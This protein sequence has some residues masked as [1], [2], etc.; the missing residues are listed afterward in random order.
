[1]NWST[2][3]E[4]CKKGSTYQ[5]GQILIP[6]KHTKTQNLSEIIATNKKEN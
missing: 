3:Q 4:P 1:M 2:Y 6:I 5:E